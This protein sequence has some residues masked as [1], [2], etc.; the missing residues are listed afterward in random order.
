[1]M[2][3]FRL[4]TESHSRN[5]NYQ[6]WQYGNHPEEVYSNSFM[7]SK[8]DYIHLNPVRAGLVEK[9]SHY[10]Y[11]SASVYV[12]G[13]GMVLIE[14]ADMS[15]VDVLNVSNVQRYDSY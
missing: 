4:A 3:R 5:K 13:K 15:I 7:W 12:D 2:E 8:L 1:M 11:S 14:K 10:V 9:A 6:F